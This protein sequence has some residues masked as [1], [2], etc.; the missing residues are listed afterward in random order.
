MLPGMVALRE[1]DVP[2][3]PL[4]QLRPLIGDVRADHLL[5]VAASSRILLQGRTVW[6]VNSTAAGGGVAEM[7]QVLVGYIRGVG[8][9]TH[10][11]T[12]QGDPLFF[13][14]TKRIHNRIH[15]V[16]GDDG[17]LG[18]A[19]TAHYREVT[20]ANAEALAPEVRAGDV[21]LLHDP[22][23]AGMARRLSAVG[24]NVVWRCH[25]GSE[26]SSEHSREAWEFLRPHLTPCDAFVFSRSSYAPDWVPPDKVSVIPPSIDPFSPKNQ[27]LLPASIPAF[28]DRIGLTEVGKELVAGTSADGTALPAP[29]Y[30]RRDGTRAAVTRSGNVIADEPLPL[31]RPLAIQVSRWDRLKDM[32]GVMAGF[33]GQVAVPLDAHLALVGPSVAE[34]ADDP[35]GAEVLAECI[36]DWRALPAAAIW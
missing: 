31:D 13:A 23:S 15:G 21:V 34:V 16:A 18:A 29:V 10:W 6:N 8:I 25:I 26:R 1:V 7:L 12:M 30:I 36:A 3:I 17:A 32:P 24:A 28:L 19:E 14:I 35:E 33:A 27:D 5:A 4:E 9:A 22:Q 11:L 20:E 2:E